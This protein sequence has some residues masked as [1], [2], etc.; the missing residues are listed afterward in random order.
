[1]TTFIPPLFLRDGVVAGFALGLQETIT[2]TTTTETYVD[3]FGVE[4][5]RDVT[6]ATVVRLA[7]PSVGKGVLFAQGAMWR[8]AAP[9][10]PNLPGPGLSYLHYNTTHGLYWW[11]SRYGQWDGD[12]YLGWA[13][14]DGAGL[15]ELVSATRLG[16]A[17]EQQ[18]LMVDGAANQPVQPGTSGGGS[19]AFYTDAIAF[20]HIA[21]D[22]AN[23]VNHQ[24]FLVSAVAITVDT[25]IFTGGSIAS[26]QNFTLAVYQDATGGRPTPTFASGYSGTSG[27]AISADPLSVSTFY[28]RFDGTHFVLV[29]FQ[30]GASGGAVMALPAQPLTVTGQEVGARTPVAMQRTQL[31]VRA[32][33]TL[34][35]GNTADRAVVELSQDAGATWATQG[36]FPFNPMAPTIDFPAFAPTVDQNW[37]VRVTLGNAGGY[38]PP[39]SAVPSVNFPIA[40]IGLPGSDLI[41]ALAIVTRTGTLY[42]D[43][44]LEKTADGTPFWG[45]PDGIRI[46]C[47]AAQ[48]NPWY[49][50]YTARAVDASGNPAPADQ[51]GVE[52][53]HC[54]EFDYVAGAV[55]VS[56]VV[57]WWEFNPVG[58]PYVKMR[59]E[60]WGYRRPGASNADR[61]LQVLP[62]GLTYLD[63]TFG[64]PPAGTLDVSRAD[65]TRL[66]TQLVFR[67]GVLDGSSPFLRDGII[68]GGFEDG[69]KGWNVVGGPYVDAAAFAAPPPSGKYSCTFGPN[70]A[71]HPSIETV[72]AYQCKPGEVYVLKATLRADPAADAQ[73]VIFREWIDAAGVT[74]YDSSATY[75]P[76]SSFASWTD[77]TPITLTVPAGKSYL[78]LLVNVFRPGPADSL[79]T[80]GYWSIDNIRVEKQV[81]TGPGMGPNGQGGVQWIPGDGLGTD[82]SGN[83][84]VRVSTSV[85]FDGA[86]NLVVNQA[87]LAIANFTGNLNVSRIDS[88]AAVA[89]ASFSGNLDVSRVNNLG[90]L[91]IYSFAGNLDVSRVNNLGTLAIYS[92]A[93]NLDVSRVN[94]LGTINITTFTGNLDISRVSNIASINIGTLSGTL[95]VT[96][97][98]ADGS[99]PINK[100]ATLYVNNLN[101]WDGGSVNVGSGGMS[102]TAG[103]YSTVIRGNSVT[104]GSVTAAGDVSVIVGGA[105]SSNGSRGYTGT[106]P[107]GARPV[108]NGGIVTGYV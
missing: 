65:P 47:G 6:V 66:G 48:P 91:A 55:Y 27:H 103:G 37:R 11:G 44:V 33:C 49:I 39:S 77:I 5:T 10:A 50:T 53:N 36:I 23:G 3:E 95:N 96:L 30:A 62:G 34:A 79:L 93:G 90:T 22:L 24:V 20:G 81:S 102:F 63:V 42:N 12:A 43:V 87:A 19:D 60:F 88:L 101:G 25:P 72:D 108:V 32:T 92:F 83:A 89:V 82:G 26:G 104:T 15:C 14:G 38:N 105:F 85:V 73:L 78:R 59:F 41:A 64:A 98:V 58:S 70:A 9:V 29:G 18:A 107:A 106:L 75:Y 31:T 7:A 45:L 4:Q 51:G 94:N 13:V 57:D 69:L 54:D 86:K 56:K 35:G 100:I 61:V 46:T 68:N 71:A 99:I 40:A 67:N 2:Y 28:F 52:S 16:D 8:P 80:A 21:P 97:Q 74:S 1:M 84:V 76:A 17:G